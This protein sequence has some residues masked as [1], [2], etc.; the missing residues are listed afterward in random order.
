MNLIGQTLKRKRKVSDD[1][2][3]HIRVTGWI[4]G[5]YVCSCTDSYGPP[6]LLTEAELAVAYGARGDSPLDEDGAQAQ[7]T[8]A[9]HAAT[10]QSLARNPKYT[11]GTFATPDPASP[12]GVF[13]SAAAA[14]KAE[15]GD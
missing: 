8:A 14:E 10:R 4:G 11:R 9:A 15:N 2:Y 5:A 7:L 6:F 13:A 1:S 3:N 12:E